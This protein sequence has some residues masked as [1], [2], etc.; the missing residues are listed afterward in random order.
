MREMYTLELMQLVEELQP[1]EG[2]YIDQFYEI[3][4]N[5]FRLKFSKK[6]EKANLQCILP[7]TLNKTDVIE[8]KEEAT[9]FS[10]AGRKR[11][12]GAKIKRVEQ[13]NNDRIIVFK[14]E[15]AELEINIIFEMFGRGN[16]VITDKAMKIL[17]A[18]QLHVFKDRAIRPGSTYAQPKGSSP[19]PF[20]SKGLEG[21]IKGMGSGEN[22]PT[23]LSYLAKR[24]GIGTI[25]VEEAISRAGVAAGT[26][27]KEMEE[28]KS[29][30]LLK[31]VI[32]VIEDCTKKQEFLIYTKDGEMIE[33]SL[34][35]LEKYSGFESQ[36]FDSFQNCLD[37]YYRNAQLT[38]EGKNED[39]E[40]T[41]SSIEK[42]RLFLV[43]ID[44]EIERNK[45][46]GNY[47][48]NNM[49]QINE[50]LKI[51]KSKKNPTKEE[52]QPATHNIEIL[53][54]NTKTKSIKI[55]AKES[56]SNA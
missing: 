26:K 12:S 38:K 2:F 44:E 32:E 6:G 4:K 52:L 37:A 36:K 13:F 53:N 18:Y 7:Y 24:L 50:I 27:I 14:T 11:I 5:R 33:L 8:I 29:E 51:A 49:H 45:Q 10:M 47:I 21:V 42:Q 16:L 1:L 31:K 39:E 17:L 34:C 28:K 20:D 56:E 15:K 22:N 25:Y 46:Y 54:V 43:E 30:I 35:K 9:N 48:M 55:R 23:I 41:K 19:N 40:K 3:E